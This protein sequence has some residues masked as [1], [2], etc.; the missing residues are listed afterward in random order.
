MTGVYTPD[1]SQDQALVRAATD[2]WLLARLLDGG[3][4][5]REDTEYSASHPEITLPFVR[6]IQSRRQRARVN[7][8]IRPKQGKKR[9]KR[10]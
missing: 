7:L 8:A 9:G 1:H 10:R 2:R 4:L 3:L 6:D 5:R